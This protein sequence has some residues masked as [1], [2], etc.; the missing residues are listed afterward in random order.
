MTRAQKPDEYGLLRE[1]VKPK[2]KLTEVK[3]HQLKQ[4]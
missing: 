1:A 4:F 3:Q 2:K